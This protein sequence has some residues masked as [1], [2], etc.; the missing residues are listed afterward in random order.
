MKLYTCKFYDMVAGYEQPVY[1][2]P[3]GLSGIKTTWQFSTD[4][5]IGC[6]AEISTDNI[7]FIKEDS[8]FLRNQYESFGEGAAIRLDVETIYGTQFSFKLDFSTYN[9]DG[10]FVEVGLKATPLLDKLSA[11]DGEKINFEGAN[12]EMLS[13]LNVSAKIR[14][15]NV[16]SGFIKAFSG[17]FTINHI[18]ST[19]GGDF[20]KL[21]WGKDDNRETNGYVLGMEIKPPQII[22]TQDGTTNVISF[23]DKYSSL[24]SYHLKNDSANT[25]FKV[26][27][28]AN[29]LFT[30]KFSGGQNGHFELRVLAA[31]EYFF[32]DGTSQLGLPF[33]S[34]VA[35]ST[36]VNE[37]RELQVN[38]T[39]ELSSAIT[40]ASNVIDVYCHIYAVPL[41][42]GEFMVATI[43]GT[44][45][46]AE[47][48]SCEMIHDL[49]RVQSNNFRSVS[50]HPL[51]D[52]INRTYGQTFYLPPQLLTN[53]RLSTYNIL[54]G[55]SRIMDLPIKDIMQ[56][57]SLCYGLCFVEVGGVYH[58]YTIDQYFANARENAIEIFDYYNYRQYNEQTFDCVLIG[59][60]EKDVAN[61]AE[62]EIFKAD[63]FK[64]AD[65]P[66]TRKVEESYS[67][68]RGIEYS[69]AQIF[70]KI[71]SASGGDE[72]FLIDKID[73]TH[74]LTTYNYQTFL[75]LNEYLSNW[76]VVNR[77]QRWLYSFIPYRASLRSENSLN[78]D[79]ELPNEESRAYCLDGIGGSGNSIFYHWNVD[80][81]VKF[82]WE[83]ISQIKDSPRA[84]KISNKYYFP[85]KYECNA[86]PNTIT[87]T[88]KEYR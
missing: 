27:V 49:C 54:R 76:R 40:Y 2:E 10:A 44:T 59:D 48:V 12:Y 11:I 46:T 78:Y 5:P 25:D 4:F 86:E 63:K 45:A 60:D 65:L 83:L 38:K 64:V 77:L 17:S 16:G 70:D 81:S 32:D 30:K 87:I 20:G 52:Y 58:V 80:V 35:S 36:M 8:D 28:K 84:L 22:V 23:P 79:S 24:I 39:F 47:F 18:Y 13:P 42:Y 34:G 53:A 68:E 50:V 6:N 37:T 31:Y 26:K 19:L 82:D 41:I 66:A 21:Y 15:K 43:D 1:Y 69:G 67:I 85:V 29:A 71:V 55:Q 88:C 75:Q 3:L 9:F 14:Q 62:F 74:W 7:K 72:L 57:L 61:K 56:T 51:F 73:N 33:D